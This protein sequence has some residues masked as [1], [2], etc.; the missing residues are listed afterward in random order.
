VTDIQ[1]LRRLHGAATPGKWF[2]DGPYWN[3]IIWRDDE[4]RIA[5]LAHSNGLDEDR[6]LATGAAI[7]ALHNA[8]PAL[9]A[10]A[11][12]LARVKAVLASEETVTRLSQVIAKA[13]TGGSISKPKSIDVAAAR[14]AI[15]EIERL[16]WPF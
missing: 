8:A 11:D 9:F 13:L 7:V 4:N 12:E 6:D 15:A 10:A 14:A 16:V 5:F 3:Q 1:E 2:V